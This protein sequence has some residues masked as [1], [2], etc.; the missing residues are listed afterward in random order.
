MTLRRQTIDFES[1]ERSPGSSPID[2]TCSLVIVEDVALRFVESGEEALLEV[3]ETSSEL[4]LQAKQI[5]TLLVD[6]RSLNSQNLCE[7]LRLETCARDLRR[8]VKCLCERSERR[9]E[10]E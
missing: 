5:G 1:V 7:R 2:G 6:L 10:H 4:S 9:R 3:E 8:I